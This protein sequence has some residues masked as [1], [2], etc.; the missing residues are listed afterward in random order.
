MPAN[1]Q[2]GALCWR[3]SSSLV[4]NLPGW[5]RDSKKPSDHPTAA[6]PLRDSRERPQP[7]VVR[8]LLECGYR[9]Q[10]GTHAQIAVTE[11]RNCS[12]SPSFPVILFHISSLCSSRYAS[13]YPPIFES[14]SSSIQSA[15]RVGDAGVDEMAGLHG[16]L[17]E[18]LDRLPPRAGHPLI[19]VAPWWPYPMA[20]MRYNPAVRRQFP[21][22]RT[23]IALSSS[24][25][26]SKSLGFRV[27]YY[28]LL[29]VFRPISCSFVSRPRD[30]GEGS[31]LPSLKLT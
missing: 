17:D 29:S 27:A 12:T 21:L 24:C 16:V 28:R 25:F 15:Y 5:S 22:P 18:P 3:D 14:A 26:R 20:H 13:G 23:T 4:H 2:R 7:T 11:E 31:G 10:C 30:S 1:Q 8:N 19:D 9:H 6:E